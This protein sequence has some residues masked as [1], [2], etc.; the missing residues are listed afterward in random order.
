MVRRWQEKINRLAVLSTV[1]ITA[2]LTA[3]IPTSVLASPP[4]ELE[5]LEYFEGSWDCQQPA[6]NQE[7]SG[8]FT[9]D[10][11]RDLNDF[12]YLGSTAQTV[13]PD[14]GKPIN[15]QEFLGYDVAAQQLINSVVVSNGN[16][17]TVAADDWQDSKLVWE[18]TISMGERSSPLRKEI[19]QD[20]AAKFTATYFVPSPDGG[21]QPIVNES[22][23]RNF[24]GSD[25]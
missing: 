11:K 23:D 1:G 6:D 7:P 14:D 8:K 24:Q 19:V 18:G 10:V 2:T 21:W 20:S 13:I 17:Y 4:P 15:S 5:R 22:C 9:R 12:W 16:S 3:S 25:N